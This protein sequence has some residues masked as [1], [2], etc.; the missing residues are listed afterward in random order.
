MNFL[1]NDD[2]VSLL[3]IFKTKRFFVNSYSLHSPYGESV[4]HWWLYIET[5]PTV[6]NSEARKYHIR[7]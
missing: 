6:W 7:P 4:K 2:P 5:F 1:I 3:F